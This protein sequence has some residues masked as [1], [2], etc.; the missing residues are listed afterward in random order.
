MIQFD[1]KEAKRRC[2][3]TPVEP[4]ELTLLVKVDHG[5]V[6]LAPGTQ[7]HGSA[8]SDVGLAGIGFR[9]TN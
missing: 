6:C 9:C 2:R 3:K 7:I 4:G 1:A 5:A 8:L